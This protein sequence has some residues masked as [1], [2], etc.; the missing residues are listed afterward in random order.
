MTFIS[1]KAMDNVQLVVK[2][3]AIWQVGKAIYRSVQPK[4]K[5]KESQNSIGGHTQN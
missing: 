5:S 3:T 1:A 4:K 2:L